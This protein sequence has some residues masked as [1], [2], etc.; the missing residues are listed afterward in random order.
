VVLVESLNGLASIL[1]LVKEMPGIALSV[2]YGLCYCCM[3]KWLF[4]HLKMKR[5]VYLIA[6]L[7]PMSYQTVLELLMACKFF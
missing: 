6:L 1:R 7:L 4:G 3:T 2:S 5:K